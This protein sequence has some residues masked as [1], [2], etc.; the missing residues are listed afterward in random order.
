MWHFH[1][2]SPPFDELP[3][4]S[5]AEVRNSLEAFYGQGHTE[6]QDEINL[7]LQVWGHLVVFTKI[8]S[9]TIVGYL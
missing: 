7:I 4:V 3:G 1:D 2:I 8:S 9:T 5:M 6:P